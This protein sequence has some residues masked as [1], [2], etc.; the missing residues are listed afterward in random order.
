VESTGCLPPE[1][2]VSE[3]G[4]V[5]LAKLGEF[6]EKVEKGETHEEVLDFEASELQARGLASV[7]TGD[8]AREDEEEDVES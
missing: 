8:L 6:S 3:A 5:L 4:R 1:K 2:I 7:D